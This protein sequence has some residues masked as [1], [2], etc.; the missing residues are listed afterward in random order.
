MSGSFVDSGGIECSVHAAPKALQRE[1][2]LIFGEGKDLSKVSAVLTAQHSS[3][4]LLKWGVPEVEKEK[5]RCLE[6][7]MAWGRAMQAC[8]AKHGC[9][10]DFFDPCSGLPVRSS[11]FFRF[12]VIV[13]MTARCFAD[14]FLFVCLFVCFLAR[15]N[16]ATFGSSS[17]T[18]GCGRVEH[19]LQRSGGVCPAARLQDYGRRRL[20]GRLARPMGHVLLPGDVGHRR[21]P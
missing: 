16:S 1:L 8:L 12:R 21:L 2:G 10:T 18:A 20:Q 4:D 19:D 14:G 13:K 9:W 17:N 7:F 3:L 6:V 15:A 11:S 5:D